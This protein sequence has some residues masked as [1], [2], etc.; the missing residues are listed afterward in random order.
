MVSAIEDFLVGKKTYIIA[1][2]GTILGILQYRG[3]YV[4]PNEVWLILGALGLAS[5]RSGIRSSMNETIVELQEGND[6]ND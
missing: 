1:L 6:S 4:V 3:A 2:I 5:L